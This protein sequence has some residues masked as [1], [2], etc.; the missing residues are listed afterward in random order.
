MSIPTLPASSSSPRLR[1]P[2]RHT[3]PE[4]IA[5][6]TSP[7][8]SKV[9]LLLAGL[10]LSLILGV[11]AA[12]CWPLARSDSITS[13]ETTHLTHLLHYWTTG[14]DLAMWELGAPRLPHAAYGLA[15]YL[16]LR[17]NGLL[18]PVP[19]EDTLTRL[20]V[21]G[22][23]YVLLPARSLAIV[24]GMVLLLLVFWA[25][26]RS[27]GVVAGLIAAALLSMV[28]DCLAHSAIA[29]SDIPFT[30]AAVLALILM[31][32]YAERP[33]AHRWWT[34]ALAIGLAW[35]MRH[36]ALLLLVLAGGVHLWIQTRESGSN[37][38]AASWLDRLLGSGLASLGLGLVAFLVLW[39]GDGLQT[40]SV[41][42]MADRITILRVP[43]QIGSLDLSDWRVPSSLLSILKQV[44]HQSQ[45]HEAYFCGA[46]GTRGWPTYFPVA[47][48]L[49]TPLG[50]LGLM[51]L[52][53]AL[54]RPRS[55]WDVIAL[56]FLAL[57]WAT[58][59][60]N[61][62]N[63][64]VR[65]AILTYPLTAPFLARLFE[66]GRLRDRVW[67]PLTM[68]A[69]L[70]FAAASFSAHPRYLSYFNEIGGGPSRGWL[71]LADSN[72]DWGQ[73]FNTLAETIQRLGI[74][75]VTT[76][77]STERRLELPGVL[78]VRFPSRSMQVPA[79]TPIRRRLYDSEGH[80]LPVYTRYVAVS[81]SRL[82][83]LYS[84]ND[85]SWLRTRKLVARVGDSI[86]LFDMDQPAETPF[87][88]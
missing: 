22:N 23:P 35:A 88:E 12:R 32:R 37:A 43:Q 51:V 57:L 67:G 64:G 71:Y 75:D 34:L 60:R 48:L 81:V 61:K 74:K 56:A 52:A 27:A 20:V 38:K 19:D 26:A 77:I 54:V 2:R 83:G 18:P 72:I 40:V 10:G 76:D 25:T 53:I 45:G 41:S 39:V 82:L 49:K 13:D 86:F 79:L 5:W 33:T 65:Y 17:A 63:I 84:Q 59:I 58:L 4:P 66:P 73:D 14:D 87:F 28:P 44:R 15:S 47:F 36:S 50:L 24:S 7:G 21:S 46:F 68:V 69:L 70:A 6:P 85:M 78:A 30:A 1:P 3:Q 16:A 9:R 8:R 42:E 31:A 29:G 55:T 11:F 62:V 80:Y